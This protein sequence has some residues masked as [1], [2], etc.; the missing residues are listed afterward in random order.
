MTWL[1]LDD[2][3]NKLCVAPLFVLLLN[4]VLLNS[5]VKPLLLIDGS[6]R[7]DVGETQKPIHCVSDFTGHFDKSSL[8]LP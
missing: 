4:R 3:T 2:A 1:L 6:L 7:S 5:V 8:K